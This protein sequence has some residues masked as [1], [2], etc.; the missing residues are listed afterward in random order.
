AVITYLLWRRVAWPVRPRDW[1]A[2]AL[3]FA[4]PLLLYLYV[5][6]SGARADYLHIPLTSEQMLHVYEISLRGFFTWITGS[7]FAGE[8]RTPAQAWVQLPAAWTL[9]RQQFGSLGIALAALGVARLAAGRRWSLLILTGLI[10]LAQVAFN[11]FYGIGDVFVLYIPAYLIVVLWLGLGAATVADVAT[12]VRLLPAPLLRFLPSLLVILLLAAFVPAAL[13]TREAVD[14]SHAPDAHVAWRIIFS[15]G[16]PD[17]AILVS[18]DRDEMTPLIY[19]QQVEGQRREVT[20]LFPL[21]AP[22]PAWSDIGAVAASALAT[23]RPVYLIKPMPGLEIK[24]RLESRGGLVQVT[25]PAVTKP[26]THPTDFSFAGLVRLVGYDIRSSTLR[27]GGALPID[28]YWQPV[29]PLPDNYH[30]FIHLFNEAG[31]K[32][33][34]SDHPPGGLFYPTNLWRPGE[35][36]RDQHLLALPSDLRRGRYRLLVGLYQYPSLQRLGEA[37]FVGEVEY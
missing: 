14:R 4:L 37:L 30:T 11:L 22:G 27:P 2:L 29:K 35:M 9:L 18:N 8:L 16:V 20:G 23:G 34:Q 17:N 36:L 1:A 32:I 21:I 33:T 26:P 19:L 25:G 28:L 7:T 6:W 3:A 12:K 13:R 15:L 5:P 31:E 24:F 10:F